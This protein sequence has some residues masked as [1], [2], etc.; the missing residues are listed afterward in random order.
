MRILQLRFKNL[1]SLV[2]EWNIDFTHPDY[3]SNGIFAITGPTGAGKTT[4]L[5]AICLALYGRTP[6]INSISKNAN[7]LMARQTGEC[8]AEVTFETASGKFRAFWYQH[9]S[10]KRADGDLQL[11]S[12]EIVNAATNEILENKLN[13]VDRRIEEITGMDF[14]RFTR[15]M[16]LA[17]GGFDSFL[18]ASPGDRAPILE[19]ITGTEIYSTISIAVFEREKVEAECLR[20]L[21]SELEGIEL[22]P[23]D[24]EENY[25]S[26]FREKLVEF[27]VLSD[28]ILG[29]Q[30]QL[31]WQT[32]FEE[33]SLRI[34]KLNSALAELNSALDTAKSCFKLLSEDQNKDFERIKQVREID[35]NLRAKLDLF[36]GLSSRLNDE[37]NRFNTC[38]KSI[39]LHEK[40]LASYDLEFQKID[41]YM[42]NSAA[43]AG[44]IEQFYS[45]CD[46]LSRLEQKMQLIN[47]GNILIKDLDT[48][49]EGSAIKSSIDHPDSSR[50]KDLQRRLTAANKREIEVQRQ[51]I[52]LKQ[53]IADLHSFSILQ[54]KMRS[55]ETERAALIDQS[56]CPLCG[57]LDHPYAHSNIPP[58]D[59][60]NLKF[61]QFENELCEI[62][63]MDREIAQEIATLGNEI[64]NVEKNQRDAIERLTIE[65]AE[66]ERAV[67]LALEPYRITFKAGI[68]PAT[69]RKT[70]EDR[71]GQ[72]KGA[73][74]KKNELENLA[75]NEQFEING[76]KRDRIQFERNLIDLSSQHS[77]F[78]AQIQDLKSS[79]EA[80]FGS[81]NPDEEE[82][83]WKEKIESKKSELAKLEIETSKLSYERDLLQK[84][85]EEL[86][87]SILASG[88][89]F[90]EPVEQLQANIVLLRELSDQTKE[91]TIILKAGLEEN[92]RKKI[93]AQG[94]LNRL[95]RQ[96]VES[97]HWS[98]LKTLIGSKDGK[99][100]REFAQ[101]MTFDR[102]IAHANRQL[103]K[104]SDRY[105]LKQS[106][107][108]Q[109]EL[110][111][112]DN[113]QAG[114]ERSVKNLSGGEGFIVSLALALGLSQMSSSKVRVDTLFLDEGFGTLDEQALEVALETLAELHQEGKVIGLI[115]HVP[116]LKERILTQIRV[117]PVS[118][119]RSRIE[120]PGCAEMALN[121]S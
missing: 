116:I 52:N 102:M 40:K 46:L 19:Q 120:G 69:I 20:S 77:Q 4:L 16:L 53:K 98:A 95:T 39:E 106:D 44:L 29:L 10:R 75:R 9:R 70:L 34:K 36:S 6:R 76:S 72:W 83:R 2:G 91:R 112:I 78:F 103:M 55:L 30:E 64:E 101:K 73:L 45:I 84:R 110:E 33:G 22:L 11:V 38:Q 57:S 3:E 54:N 107:N 28:K 51:K 90:Q 49:N 14:A 104:M 41:W 115:S 88:K 50:L 87:Q 8:F 32:E 74:Q 108:G 89:E 37:K 96:Q 109:L 60:I 25:R 15:S 111:V 100:F 81:K 97:D 1:N 63:K 62:E 65:Q 71:L 67:N 5:D 66:L 121:H 85:N 27:K 59:E 43:D 26:E 7:E 21:N 47:Q 68:T 80:L 13:A 58:V 118:G 119:G 93:K 113:Y 24:L 114:I 86:N 92:E 23:N 18:K 82:S 17:Q 12:R 79:R 61:T 48:S 35:L 31:K 117:I 56:P 42:Q 94:L 99:K 105:L